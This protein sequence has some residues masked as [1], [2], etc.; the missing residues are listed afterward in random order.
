M[1]IN[2]LRLLRYAN[3]NLFT[4]L[5]R[6]FANFFPTFYLQQFQWFTT[7]RPSRQYAI[8]LFEMP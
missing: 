1:K 8:S 7:R 2:W 4:L 5:E 3:G 6:R